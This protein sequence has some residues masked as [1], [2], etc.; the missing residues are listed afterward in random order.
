MRHTGCKEKLQKYAEEV[1]QF[2][3]AL[4]ERHRRQQREEMQQ[5]LEAL[6]RKASEELLQAGGYRSRG[7][8]RRTILTS[9]GGVTVRVRCYQ[10][11]GGRRV[12]PS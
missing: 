10:H 4:E 1:K 11:K 7:L 6:D 8:K 12:Y 2:E 5:Y 9:V 3:K